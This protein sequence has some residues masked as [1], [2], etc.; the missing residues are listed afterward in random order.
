MRAWFENDK[1]RYLKY[2]VT[3]ILLVCGIALLIQD[4]R[5]STEEIREGIL[6]NS[7]GEGAK[8][9]EITVRID[10]DEKNDL[11]I[12]VSEQK[13]EDSDVDMFFQDCIRQI[14][15]EMLGENKSPD[16]VTKDLNLMTE[17]QGKPVE[18]DWKLENYEVIN[19]YGEIQEE[20]LKKE[21]TVVNLEAVLTYTENPEKQAMYE[22]T[23]AVYPK[24][25]T[26]EEQFL[27]D[28]ETEIEKKD[29]ESQTKK[30]LEL[31]DSLEGKEL[32]Y[33]RRMNSRGAVLMVMAI[34]MG[35]LFYVQEIQKRGEKQK[36]KQRQMMRDYPEIISKLTLFLGAGMTMKRAWKK[37]VSD[38]EREKEIWGIRYAYEEMKMTYREM[39]SGITEAE[40][41]ERFGRRCNLQEY[42]RLG[43]LLSQNIRKG[44]KGLSHILRLEAA[45]AFENR[46]AAVRKYGEEAGTRLLLPMFIMFAVVLVMVIV[47]AFLSLQM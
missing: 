6:R 10:G 33:Y 29:K 18:I 44:T 9:E 28:V 11:D 25:L 2:G 13:Y 3:G 27:Q 8:T 46:K 17:L 32:K 30:T 15:K 31:P 42:I 37:V 36:E 7:Y 45:Q 26:G 43:A 5:I 35:V 39:E 40:S 23:V 41:Y 21:G 19:I 1:D 20:G 4:Y 22:C 16:S 24:T 38:Y 34:L 47:P 14:E 12:Q